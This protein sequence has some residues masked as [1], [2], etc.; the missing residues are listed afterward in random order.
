MSFILSLLRRAQ[1]EKILGSI[2]MAFK[3]HE[4]QNA[5]ETKKIKIAGEL[6]RPNTDEY[7]TKSVR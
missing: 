6:Y 5:K 4:K 1:L 7:T 2:L 3:S